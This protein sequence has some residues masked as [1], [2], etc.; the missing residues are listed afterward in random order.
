MKSKTIHNM[1]WLDCDVERKK[2]TYIYT[3]TSNLNLS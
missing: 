2:I 1:S 3:L